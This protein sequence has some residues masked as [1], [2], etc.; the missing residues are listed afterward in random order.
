MATRKYINIK[1]VKGKF[2][3]GEVNIPWGTEF[4][5]S[6][7]GFISVLYKDRE[8]KL[9][10]ETSENAYRYFAYNDDGQGELRKKLINETHDLMAQVRDRD[11]E[12][13]R[14]FHSQTA[15]KYKKDPNNDTE[16]SWNR[17][18]VHTAPIADLEEIKRIVLKMK[19]GE[20]A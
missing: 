7:D 3:C 18:K 16:W 4:Y 6:E 13:E 10:W 5:V 11:V 12:F 15:L 1:R 17:L 20:A 9:C 14:F 8:C 2:H 19:R